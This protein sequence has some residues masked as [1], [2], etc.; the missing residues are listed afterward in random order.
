MCQS[1]A[2]SDGSGSKTSGA[3]LED[4]CGS[5]AKSRTLMPAAFSASTRSSGV[6][7]ILKSG[8]S[9]AISVGAGE[10]SSEDVDG[11][12]SGV[13]SIG[14]R[15][16]MCRFLAGVT[17][18]SAGAESEAE[19]I[20]VIGVGRI[21]GSEVSAWRRFP[22]NV[23]RDGV[24]CT[25]KDVVV[26]RG[27]LVASAITTSWSARE[28]DGTRPNVLS[29]RRNGIVEVSL[30]IIMASVVVVVVWR[31][32]WGNEKGT[33]HSRTKLLWAWLAV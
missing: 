1:V 10:S 21:T 29:R 22:S 28:C 9:R 5:Y 33:S 3:L 14:S 23:G 19:S 6:G 18:G 26:V 11:V 30:L 12:G 25:G 8:T 7:S 31:N 15:V 13:V 2:M 20:G 32:N 27:A 16:K 17:V 4:G 24:I